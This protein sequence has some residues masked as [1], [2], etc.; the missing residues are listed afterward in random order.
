M[1]LVPRV[2]GLLADRELSGVRVILGGIIPDE[3]VPKLLELGVSG[4]FGPGTSTEDIIA[5]IHQA[6]GE[7]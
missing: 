5:H 6:V 2:M 1:A 7:V 3:D 4:V